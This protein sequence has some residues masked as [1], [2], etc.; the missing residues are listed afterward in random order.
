MTEAF[1]F[2]I[3]GFLFAKGITKNRKFETDDENYGT[4]IFDGEAVFEEG[5]KLSET[6]I[7]YILENTRIYISTE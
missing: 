4:L 7:A 6:D 2:Y 5:Y 3:A 1:K